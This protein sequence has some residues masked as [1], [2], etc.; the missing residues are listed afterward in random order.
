[1]TKYITDL[2]TETIHETTDARPIDKATW[3]YTDRYGKRRHAYKLEVHG[4]YEDAVRGMITFYEAALTVW[5]QELK[6][7]KLRKMQ[8]APDM[9]NLGHNGG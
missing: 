6:D 3:I 7:G 9:T 4:T 8:T 1:M 5:R 2:H